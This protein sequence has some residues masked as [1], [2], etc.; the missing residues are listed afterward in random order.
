[1]ERQLARMG[2]KV[3]LKLNLEPHMERMGRKEGKKTP[4]TQMEL[5]EKIG[6]PQG[7]IS[8]WVGSKIDSYNRQILEK[9][10]VY[11]EC[12]IE[13][14]FKVEREFVPDDTPQ[15]KQRNVRS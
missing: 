9:L 13:D 7:T 10:M 3:T 12:E 14:L 8:R 11:F 15:K 4:L 1:M 2:E 6:V 5:A